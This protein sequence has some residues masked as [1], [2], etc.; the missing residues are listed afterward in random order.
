MGG[1]RRCRSCGRSL[2]G[3]RAQARTCGPACRQRAY[4]QCH[5]TVITLITPPK[6]R[7]ERVIHSALWHYSFERICSWY[8]GKHGSQPTKGNGIERTLPGQLAFQFTWEG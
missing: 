8:E 3:R 2:E 5:A 4:R 1:T 7:P 6:R